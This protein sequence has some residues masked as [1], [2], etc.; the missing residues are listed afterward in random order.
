MVNVVIVGTGDLAYALSHLFHINNSRISG[1]FLE[2]TKTSIKEGGKTFHETEVPL[3]PIED[4]LSHADVVILAIPARA[5][6]SFVPHYIMAL[7][8]KILVDCTNSDRKG[9]DLDSLVKSTDIR[10][11]KA[12]N[13][14]GA[15]DILANKGTA[16]KNILTKMCSPNKNAL[17]VVRRVA[18]QSFGLDVKVFPYE[19]YTQ[20]AKAQNTIGKEWTHATWI[21]LV[22]FVLTEFYAC[23]RY[24]VEKGYAWF[25]LPI[26]VRFRF[27][28]FAGSLS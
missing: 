17:E 7:K 1:N 22:T 5:L 2:V 18:E 4:A 14:I 27:P 9:E 13:D 24:N 12:F 8:D 21:M 3:T 26:Q 10:W 20:L 23:W 11:V 28:E 6:K 16:K 19:R 15:A 25:H